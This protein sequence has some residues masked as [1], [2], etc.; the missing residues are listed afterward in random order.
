[1]VITDLRSENRG[2]HVQGYGALNDIECNLYVEF[3]VVWIL[4]YESG[5]I[6]DIVEDRRVKKGR[7]V[8]SPTNTL[9][10]VRVT[11]FIIVLSAGT[12]VHS[13]AKV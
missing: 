8:G 12:F 11:I 1:M 6:K 10:L 2:K 7:H 9:L 13:V 5:T 3:T 4:T